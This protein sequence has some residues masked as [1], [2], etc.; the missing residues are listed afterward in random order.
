MVGKDTDGNLR[1]VKEG[2]FVFIRDGNVGVAII[3]F[4]VYGPD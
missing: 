3:A 1:I 2:I 4:A